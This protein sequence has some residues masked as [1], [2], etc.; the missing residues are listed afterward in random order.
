VRLARMNLVPVFEGG[1]AVRSPTHLPDAR[2]SLRPLHPE[3]RMEALP[4]VR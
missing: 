2:V 1:A 3:P 4:A